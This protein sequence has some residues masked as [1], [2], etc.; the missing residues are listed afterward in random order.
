MGKNGVLTVRA[1][2]GLSGDMMLAGLFA[3]SGLTDGDLAAMTRE[4]RLPALDGA[5]RVEERSLNGIAGYGCR[6][7]LPHEHAHR[8]CADIAAVIGA[9]AM[10][11]RA[12]EL[13]LAAF[14]LL[15]EA[16][17]EVHGQ[18]PEEV[19]FHEVGALDSIL[20]ICLVCRLFAEI[21]PARFVCSPLP[22]ADGVVHCAHGTAPAPAP[23][24]LRLLPGVPVRGFSG[25]GETVTPTALALVKSLGADFGPW[26]EMCVER[27]AISYGTKVFPDAPNGAVWAL[28]R[29]VPHASARSG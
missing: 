2:S 16:E 24:V 8:T 26:P 9:S 14:S 7:D 5:L 27:T 17:G 6:I 22:L 23:A 15:A 19:R 11:E 29:S 1:L 20:D 4:L 13:A 28:G 12:R 21:S 18:K 25:S 3:V 10:P